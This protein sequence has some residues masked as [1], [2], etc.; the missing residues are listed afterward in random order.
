MRLSAAAKMGTGSDWRGLAPCALLV[1][2]F[3]KSMWEFH[4][5]GLSRNGVGNVVGWWIASRL[6]ARE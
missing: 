4:L 3:R 2:V 5:I 6:A 1:K